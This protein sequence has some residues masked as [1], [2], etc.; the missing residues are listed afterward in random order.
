MSYDDPHLSY[1]EAML[2]IRHELVSDYADYASECAETNTEPMPFTMWLRDPVQC[3]QELAVPFI[4]W[5]ASQ[6]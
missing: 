5:V 3:D 2:D 1:E 6:H 4:D